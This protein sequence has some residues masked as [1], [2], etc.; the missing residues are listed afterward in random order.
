VCK[1]AHAPLLLLLLPLLLVLSVLSATFFSSLLEEDDACHH[2]HCLHFFFTAVAN[3]ISAILLNTNGKA[4]ITLMRFFVNDK[5]D[6]GDIVVKHRLTE[7]MWTDINPKPKQGTVFCVF[8]GHVMVIG[9][10]AD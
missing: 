5:I 10:T 6:E 2:H 1:T 4:N 3:T 7:E 8:R 9:S